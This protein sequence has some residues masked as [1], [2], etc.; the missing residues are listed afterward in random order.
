[1][2]EMCHIR[3]DSQHM[4]TWVETEWLIVH[5]MCDM[6]HSYVWHDSWDIGVTSLHPWMNNQSLWVETEW[7]IVHSWMKWRH[8]THM[9]ETCHIRDESQH[10]CTWVQTEWLIVH[11]W[12]KRRH[13]THMNETCHI[14][15][16]SQHMCT[17]VQTEWLIVHYMCDMTHSYVWHDSWDI[18][19]TSLHP[20][21]CRLSDWLFIHGWSNVTPI[22][23]M[24]ESCH[25]YEWVMSHIQMSHVTHIPQRHVCAMWFISQC[26]TGQ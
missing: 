25:T 11:S 15:D 14:R 20:H 17:W 12:M 7:L 24:N 13:V 9:N 4:C 22:P 21:E 1:M 23:H 16:E 19:V 5:Y 2:N 6:T 3:H 18:G 26:H 10:M 8:V